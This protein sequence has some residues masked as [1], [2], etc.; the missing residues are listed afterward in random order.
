M[1]CSEGFSLLSLAGVTTL[2]MLMVVPVASAQ[3]T[4]SP[5]PSLNFQLPAGYQIPPSDQQCILPGQRLNL[6][7]IIA[8]DPDAK[9]IRAEEAML[10]AQALAAAKSGKLDPYHQVQTLGKL[11]IFDPNLSV[12]NNVACSYCHDPAAGYGNGASI[13]SVFT[14]GSNPGS[15]PITVHGAYP[16]NRIAKRN[17]QSYVYA[18]YLP[19]LHYNQSQ[20]DFYGG[21][22]WDG[23]ATGYKLQNSAANQ[24]QGPPLDTQEMANPDSACVV[25]KLSLSKYKFFFEQ[26][27]GVGSLELNWPSDV[28]QICSTPAGAAVLG[29]NPTP[30][31]LSPTDRT[32]A[33]KDFDEFAQ[34]IAAYEGSDSV[35]PFTSKFDYFLAG[36]AT[37][38]TQEMNGYELFRGKGSCNTCHLDGR[39]ST[40]KGGSD[41][42]QAASLQPLFTDTTYNNL[43][44][45]KNVGL[46][47][48]SEDTPDQWG[49]T[50]NPLGFGFTDEG[51]GLFLDGYYGA[52]PDLDWG[53]QLPQFEGKFQTSTARDAA[54]V[55]YPGFV[56][57]Y[58]HNGYLTSLKEVVHFYNT[59]DVYPFNVLSGNCPK[60]TVEKV[61]CWPMPEDS[62][63]E[64]T[65]IG[66]LGLSDE[67]EN[68]IVAFLN[69][70]VDGY[71]P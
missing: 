19:P 56:K 66:K 61:T 28:Q 67:E 18:S 17:P 15:V 34:A 3:G 33:N 11:E 36:K 23:R 45:P 64:N 58:M 30:L 51:M 8:N 9:R 47:W 37:L 5:P 25:W 63:N 22:F 60:G 62:N 53:V 59:R 44:L 65:T 48:Y 38:T 10:E 20:A 32:L 70:L 40:Q 24:A 42:G 2:A 43:G 55:P 52:P 54:Q 35:S 29:G 26:V 12:N 41:T 7:C 4:P 68:D 1:K 21:N 49:F 27:F 6:Q 13:L 71:K 14:G 46:P 57:A 39:S 16:N 69:T 50:A 31:Q